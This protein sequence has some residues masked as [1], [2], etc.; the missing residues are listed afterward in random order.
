MSKENMQNIKKDQPE[1][2]KSLSAEDAIRV[3]GKDIAD[4]MVAQ[5]G[6]ITNVRGLL[7]PI[8]KLYEGRADIS[9]ANERSSDRAEYILVLKKLPERVKYH[10]LNNRNFDNNKAKTYQKLMD[11]LVSNI[12]EE[13]SGLGAVER[14][15]P[16]E[17]LEGP[18]A[19]KE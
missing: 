7:E 1:I 12:N 5:A 4:D 15:K 2:R 16:I 3:Y 8:I 6:S 11:E 17:L 13:L 10:M 14:V 9:G 18:L 19:I